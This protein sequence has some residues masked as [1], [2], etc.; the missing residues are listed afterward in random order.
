MVTLTP[1]AALL[2]ELAADRATQPARIC[3]LSVAE[4]GVAGAGVSM[5]TSTGTREAICATDAVSARIEDLHITLGEGPCIDTLRTG[6]PILV[7]DVDEP[8][9]RAVTLWPRFMDGAGVAGVRGLFAF[10]LS[11]GAMKLGSLVFYRDRPG[12]LGRDQLSQ[13]LVAADACALSLLHLKAGWEQ[14]TVRDAVG[15]D[16]GSGHLAQ[17]HQ[18]TGMVQVQLDVSTEEAFLVLRARAFAT[19]RALGEVASDVVELRLRFSQ[20]DR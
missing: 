16:V 17:V 13:A 7:G 1:W 18:A 6:T 2:A 8:G 19:D 3:E 5:A 9:D 20:E 12:D 14:E 4:L 11:I 10:P 15:L